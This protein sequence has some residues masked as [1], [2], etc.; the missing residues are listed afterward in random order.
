MNKYS[1]IFTLLLLNCQNNEQLTIN[2]LKFPDAYRLSIVENNVESVTF[3]KNIDSYFL[4]LDELKDGKITYDSIGRLISYNMYPFGH[5]MK[6]VY[7]N[8]NFIK[9][10]S[11]FSDYN[12]EEKFKNLFISDSLTMITYYLNSMNDINIPL[13]HIT[14]Y[15][16]F[17]EN[18]ILIFEFQK[19]QID[20]PTHRHQ[21]IEYS[22]SKDLKVSSLKTNYLLSEEK[23]KNLQEERPNNWKNY[24]PKTK[25]DT[26]IYNGN[27]IKQ[28]NTEIQFII[29]KPPLHIKT[30]YDEQGLKLKSVIQDSIIMNYSYSFRE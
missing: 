5:S 9:Q 16:K 7:E 8:K 30:Y 12:S 15:Y 14:N 4:Y 25:Y 6:L 28:Q 2:N 27:K 17:N 23:S 26:F 18:G 3:R 10:H 13:N 29:K 1:F 24:Y 21:T 11:T 20:F 19:G 22:Y